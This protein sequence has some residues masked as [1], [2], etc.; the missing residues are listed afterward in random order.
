MIPSSITALPV[1]C[2]TL[3]NRRA[4]RVPQGFKDNEFNLLGKEKQKYRY[5][6]AGDGN[7][8]VSAAPERSTICSCNFSRRRR[9]QFLRASD[10]YFDL[11]LSGRIGPDLLSEDRFSR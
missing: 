9:L 7:L 5:T 4:E 10:G 6:G 11:F 3:P 1:R 2:K 8:R